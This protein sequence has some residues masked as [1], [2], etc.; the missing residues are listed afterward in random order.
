MILQNW[1]F[2]TLLGTP[3]PIRPPLREHVKADVLII[4]AGAAG[5]A[6]ALRFAGSG[7]KVVVLDRNICG[8]SSTGKSAGFLTPDSEL[9]LAQLRRRFGSEGAR[10]LWNVPVNGIR[11]MIS[12]IQ[13]NGIQCDLLKQDSLFLGKGRSGWRAVQD[14]AKTREEF[15]FASKLYNADEVRSVL[16]SKAYSG[17]VRYADTHAVD[18]L[19]YAQGVKRA[20]LDRGVDV[21]ES[22]EVIGLKDHT[23]FTHMGSVTADQIVVCADKLS[24]ELSKY[25]W[26]VYYV[27]TFLAVS[28]PLSQTDVHELF[29]EES[30]QCWD[31]DLDYTYFRLTGDQRLLV[32]GETFMSSFASKDTTTPEIINHVVN[33]LRLRIPCLRRIEFIQYW[34]GRIDFTRDL[35]PT[36]VRDPD[37]TWVHY[38]L[39]CVGLPWATFCGDFV[40][41]QVLGG[42]D[43]GDQ[44]YYRY[45]DIHRRFLLPVWL[46]RIFGKRIVFMLNNAWAKYY[47]TDVGRNEPRAEDP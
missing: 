43:A 20:L 32:G 6:A 44:H 7:S 47:Q 5:L 9:E 46:E 39:G 45:F 8:G 35:L 24:P 31:S 27:Q 34:P 38:V 15:G 41:R 2:T 37:A 28:E 23:A 19:R 36:I 16:G 17:A 14:E 26:N 42:P 10:D 29:P 21:Y 1:W 40:A 13:E 12:T 30:L 18:G 33:D 25:S 22:S 11:I 3:Q 4:G